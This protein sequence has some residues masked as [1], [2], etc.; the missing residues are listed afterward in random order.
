[1]QATDFL[2]ADGKSI[3]GAGGGG[4]TVTTADVQLTN[5]TTFMPDGMATQ[6][7]AN[8]YIEGE[9]QKII[10]DAPSDGTIY[11][12]QNSGWVAVLV[13][14]LICLRTTPRQRAMLATSRRAVIWYPAT[15]TVTRRR[16][17]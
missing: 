4:G 7:D 17:G 9:L 3:I 10:P 8:A 5:P 15:L 2:D 16:L 12:R 11:G 1:M 6:E 14:V 13:A